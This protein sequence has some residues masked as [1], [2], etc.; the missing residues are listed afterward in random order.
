V[1]AGL[2]GEDTVLRNGEIALDH[3]HILDI[4]LYEAEVAVDRTTLD[5]QR[6]WR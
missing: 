1:D 5:L 6:A 4:L 3:V 2:E